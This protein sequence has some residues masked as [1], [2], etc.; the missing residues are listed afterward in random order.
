MYLWQ[1][2]WLLMCLSPIYILCL[3][4]CFSMIGIHTIWPTATKCVS[5]QTNYCR[6]DSGTPEYQYW[7]TVTGSV[8]TNYTR[9]DSGT[10]EYQYWP[11][12]TGRQWQA[13]ETGTRPAA[14]ARRGWGRVVV[15]RLASRTAY[16]TVCHTSNTILSWFMLSHDRQ[17]NGLP[18]MPLPSVVVLVTVLVA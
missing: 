7:P 15:A 11:T 6:W 2:D 13:A 12:V 18:Y 1:C 16:D 8:Q 9:W 3:C 5:V 10:P 4:A 17:L 14:P